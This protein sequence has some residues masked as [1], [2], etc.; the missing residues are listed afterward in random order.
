MQ[1][2]YV[3]LMMDKTNTA[4]LSSDVFAI[5]ITVT[6]TIKILNPLSFHKF[7]NKGRIEL[8]CL[9]IAAVST[10]DAISFIKCIV[11]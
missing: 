7:C 11:L 6:Q 10:V 9:C 2:Q 3:H 4:N 8:Y 1:L 5:L